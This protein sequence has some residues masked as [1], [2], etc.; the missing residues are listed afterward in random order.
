MAFS[1]STAS[2]DANAQHAP[3][4][5][6]S[7]M[8][9]RKSFQSREVTVSGGGFE[10]EMEEDVVMVFVSEMEDETVRDDVGDFD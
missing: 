8:G 6:W 5:C 3:H 9:V 7:L 4:C 10:G 2:V 1:A